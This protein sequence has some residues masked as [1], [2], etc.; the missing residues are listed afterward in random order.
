MCVEKLDCRW[1]L[2]FLGTRTCL[3]LLL[4]IVGNLVSKTNHDFYF[5]HGDGQFRIFSN[6]THSVERIVHLVLVDSCHQHPAYLECDGQFGPGG[7]Y[8]KKEE[9]GDQASVITYLNRRENA[10]F[11]W[12]SHCL[13]QC[14]AKDKYDLLVRTR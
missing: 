2:L 8:N 6:Q 14:M 13:G 7:W 3:L 12:K 5:L 9:K 1:N 10:Q 4:V 11:H